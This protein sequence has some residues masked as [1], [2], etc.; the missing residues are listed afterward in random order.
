MRQHEHSCREF[1][2]D[3]LVKDLSNGCCMMLAVGGSTGPGVY[4]SGDD[5]QNDTNGGGEGASGQSQHSVEQLVSR[6]FLVPL[7]VA[8]AEGTGVPG[9]QEHSNDL[10]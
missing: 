1:A 10:V 2:S 9:H 8:A 6:V 3:T 7:A 4:I 5:P